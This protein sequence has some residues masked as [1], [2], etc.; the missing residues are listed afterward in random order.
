MHTIPP[1]VDVTVYAVIG[2]PLSADAVHVTRLDASPVAAT[3]F[4]GTLGNAAGVAI[5][6]LAE[7]VVPAS[8][9]A[10]TTTVYF[11]PLVNPLM[12]QLVVV[13]LHTA[14]PGEAVAR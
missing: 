10:V 4:V 8:F 12:V 13:V 14:P 5:A 6:E 1:G 2:S 11:V 7:D 3:T 9:V